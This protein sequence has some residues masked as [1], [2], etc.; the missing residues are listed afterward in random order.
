M[1]A[2]C[3]GETAEVKP[4]SICWAHVRGFP[5]WP[6]C[7]LDPTNYPPA[8]KLAPKHANSVPI[9]FYGTRE[10]AW[11]NADALQLPFRG[12]NYDRH[13]KATKRNRG[14]QRAIDECTNDPE[15]FV[16]D[17]N[18]VAEPELPD[19][20][21]SYES[22]VAKKIKQAKSQRR[23]SASDAPKPVQRA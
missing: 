5:W 8:L 14:L 6:A 21:A 13:V 10:V 16:F 17:Y 22:P 3:D 20:V 1:L 4:G 2:K 11:M 12:A 19:D 23:K 15:C 18:S 7:V 9:F